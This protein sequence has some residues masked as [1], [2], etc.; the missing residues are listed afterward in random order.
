MKI[1]TIE[2]HSY[3]HPLMNGQTR[4]GAIILITDLAG[5]QGCGEI[6]PL[7]KWS[8]ETLEDALKSLNDNLL[9]IKQ[10]DWNITNC[11]DKLAKLELLPSAAFGLESAILAII[12]P[13]AEFQIQTSALLMGST[14]E[15]L[16]QAKL[17]H[18]EG[19]TSAKLKVS[20]LRFEEAFHTIN[21]LKD[22]F[23]LRIDVNR[24]WT[25]SDSLRFFARFP[26][27]AFDYV[28]EPFQ[29]PLDLPHFVHPLAVDE[30]FPEPLSFD[31]LK[32][33]PSLKAI[34]Y[35]PT[36]QGGISG[37]IPLYKWANQNKI[38]V[39]ISSCFESDIG[40]A[41]VASMAHRLSLTAPIGIGTYYFQKRDVC[42]P[43]IQFIGSK[44]L[45]NFE[46][47]TP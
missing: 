22:K 2:I 43:L 39:V 29:N 34:V 35:K 4:S 33:L 47:G 20:N 37:C 24:A 25:T 41:C 30:S 42:T 8:P 32:L 16:E 28:E 45:F 18:L 27:D 10:I 36:I 21:L 40:L 1:R 7:P 31:L 38:D 3:T 26:L 44:A 46:N 23:R 14:E 19:Y 13:L 6:A 5:N 17:R 11:F 12:S 9:A 15:I